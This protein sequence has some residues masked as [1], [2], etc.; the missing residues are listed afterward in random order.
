MVIEATYVQ[1][2]VAIFTFI[3]VSIVM[4]NTISSLR[5][6]SVHSAILNGRV[7]VINHKKKSIYVRKIFMYGEYLNTVR[8]NIPHTQYVTEHVYHVKDRTEFVNVVVAPGETHIFLQTYSLPTGRHDIK[9]KRVHFL[10]NIEYDM[11]VKNR[12]VFSDI[13]KVNARVEKSIS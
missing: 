3:N 11:V 1:L 10:K 5:E 8:V 12:K 6:N 4:F 13:E 7:A 9:L 2:A